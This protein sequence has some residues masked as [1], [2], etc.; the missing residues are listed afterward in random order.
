MEV[1]L[2]VAAVQPAAVAMAAAVASLVATGPAAMLVAAA[3]AL[4][5]L[6]AASVVAVAVVHQAAAVVHVPVAVVTQVVVIQV[7]DTDNNF[8][9]HIYAR[10]ANLAALFRLYNRE[11]F[12]SWRR[13]V[14]M[15]IVHSLPLLFHT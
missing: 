8:S 15:L 11:Y 1:A 5:A 3:V 10:A 9:D 14:C 12:H 2:S 7:V 4:V 13:V 6:C